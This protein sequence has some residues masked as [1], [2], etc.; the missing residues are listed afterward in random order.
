M[1]DRP[2]YEKPSWRRW[3]P[4]LPLNRRLS[5]LA[6][7]TVVLAVV[8]A[9]LGNGIVRSTPGSPADVPAHPAASDFAAT[10]PAAFCPAEA[11]KRAVTRA[12]EECR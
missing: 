4:R 8:G 5:Y 11:M 3:R 12:P 9:I 1:T 7:G 6:G 2:I 10:A